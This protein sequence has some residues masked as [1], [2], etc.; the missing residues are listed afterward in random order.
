MSTTYGADT[1]LTGGRGTPD[2]WSPGSDGHNWTQTRGNQTLSYDSVNHQLVLTFNG[3]TTSGVMTY[4]GLTVADCEITVNAVQTG[5]SDIIGPAMRVVDANNYIQLVI[6]N[7][8][9]LLELRKDA[10]STFT[11]VAFAAFTV[12]AGTKYSFRFRAIGSTY[13]GKVWSGAEPAAWNI[14]PF[15][16]TSLTSGLFGVAGRPNATGNTTK[17]DSF[18]AQSPVRAALFDGYGG[19][20]S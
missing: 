9:N 11:T 16:D 1:A 17:Y 12:S 2:A 18:L 7:S 19:M 3:S 13:W 20:F 6:G 15:V 14:G 10:A 4:A 5:A 8:A